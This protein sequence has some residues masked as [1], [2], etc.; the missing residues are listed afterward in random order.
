ML[1]IF[2]AMQG[3]MLYFAPFMEYKKKK[4][5]EFKVCVIHIDATETKTNSLEFCNNKQLN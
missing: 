1:V 5:W 3:L 4:L 2:G